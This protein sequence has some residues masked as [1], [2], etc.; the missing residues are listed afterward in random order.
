MF[1]LGRN[2]HKVDE[3]VVKQAQVIQQVGRCTAQGSQN[4]TLV[5]PTSQNLSVKKQES[6][7][8]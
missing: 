6:T 8:L 4:R 5:L 2:S 1:S 3:L 7:D